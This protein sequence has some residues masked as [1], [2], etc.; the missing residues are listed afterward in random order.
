MF[1]SV[2]V[3]YCGFS[4]VFNVGF[5]MFSHVFSRVYVGFAAGFC[6]GLIKLGPRFFR[7]VYTLAHLLSD[8]QCPFACEQFHALHCFWI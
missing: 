8:G 3:V 2:S 6:P 7:G 4:L 5:P 1:L